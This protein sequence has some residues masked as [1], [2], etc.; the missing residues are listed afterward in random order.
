MVT[1]A[2][3]AGG[4][5]IGPR[6]RFDDARFTQKRRRKATFADGRKRFPT[7]RRERIQIAT[8]YR[9]HPA[10]GSA[11]AHHQVL[12]PIL[13]Q[14]SRCQRQRLRSRRELLFR[15]FRSFMINLQRLWVL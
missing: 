10:S 7:L 1:R 9:D 6:W 2:K 3:N 11:I 8:V 15:R 14:I 13:V 5:E 4:D 12:Y